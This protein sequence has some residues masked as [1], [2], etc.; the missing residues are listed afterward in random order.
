MGLQKPAREAIPL[1][2]WG[3]DHEIY[4]RMWGMDFWLDLLALVGLCR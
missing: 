1:F 2:L 4:E 3:W